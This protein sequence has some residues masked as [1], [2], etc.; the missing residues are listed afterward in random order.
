MVDAG[1]DADDAYAVLGITDN[2]ASSLT[3]ADIRRAYRAKALRLHPDKNR[4]DP[5]AAAKFAAVFVAYEALCDPAKRKEID[6][7]RAARARRAA[8]RMQMDGRRRRLRD[9][10][11]HRENAAEARGTPAMDPR[12]LAR[13]QDEI[14]R[15]RR[16]T[17]ARAVG[18]TKAAAGRREEGDNPWKEVP[19]YAAFVNAEVSFEELERSVLSSR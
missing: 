10:L 1:A 16:E 15:L 8:E 2:D 11:A 12:A 17:A 19:G 6:D 14:E 4:D 7:A 13:M 5:T 9:E 18:Q 3:P